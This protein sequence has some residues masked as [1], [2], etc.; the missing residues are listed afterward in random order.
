MTRRIQALSCVIAAI[1]LMPLR[2]LGQESLGAARQL[3]ASAEYQSALTMLSSLLASSP[4]PQER[5]SIEL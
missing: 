3:Y 2:V 1:L 5:Q 4:P